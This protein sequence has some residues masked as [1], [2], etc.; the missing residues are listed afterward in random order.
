MRRKLRIYIYIEVFLPVGTSNI[1]PCH[2]SA[3]SLS[4]CLPPHR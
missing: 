1:D 3:V 4:N 2:S